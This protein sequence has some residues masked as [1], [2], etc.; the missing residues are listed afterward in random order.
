[1]IVGDSAL[2]HIEVVNLDELSIL[3]QLHPRQISERLSHRRREQQRLHLL[4]QLLYDQID[5][6]FE[7]HI[8]HSIDLIHDEHL[9]V[10]PI[11]MARLIQML[12]QTPRSR[13]D[14]V[15]CCDML[16][17]ELYVLASDD[18]RRAQIVQPTERAE[19][20]KC[21]HGKLAGRN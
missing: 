3:R 10:T 1:M 7:A 21:L 5:L 14:N 19:H 17:F 13:Y 9:E 20:L 18:Q 2:D 8:E 12:Q 6:L 11:E 4:W 16:A 15:H